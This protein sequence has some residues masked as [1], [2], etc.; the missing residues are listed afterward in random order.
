MKN[1]NKKQ[2]FSETNMPLQKAKQTKEKYETS[3]SSKFNY[4][5]LRSKHS[6]HKFKAK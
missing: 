6:S 2:Q 1:Q 4:W 3:R 5:S